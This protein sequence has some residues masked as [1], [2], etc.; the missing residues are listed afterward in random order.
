[1]DIQVDF[2]H[3]LA[4]WATP[5]ESGLRL[6]I[7]NT[8]FNFNCIHKTANK[9]ASRQHASQVNTIGH[10]NLVMFRDRAIKNE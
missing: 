1:M 8:R 2:S 9:T 3:S 7:L 4:P 6:L 5:Y 10:I